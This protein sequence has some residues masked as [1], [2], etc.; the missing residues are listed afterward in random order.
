MGDSH[1]KYSNYAFV[2]AIKRERALKKSA[3]AGCPQIYSA[4][5]SIL[6]VIEFRALPLLIR[7][8]A[9]RTGF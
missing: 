7:T 6:A 5:K 8:W 2:R 4:Q 9:I 1:T 3:S